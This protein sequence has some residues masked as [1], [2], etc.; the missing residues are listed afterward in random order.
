MFIVFA[1]VTEKEIT[2]I[3]KYNNELSLRTKKKKNGLTTKKFI[4][5]Y[6]Y[7]HNNDKTLY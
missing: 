4:S 2:V 5:F 3:T 6:S 7:F 1:N